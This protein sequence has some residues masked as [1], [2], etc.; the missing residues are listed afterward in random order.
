M[1]KKEDKKKKIIINTKNLNFPS[2]TT[3]RKL[4]NMKLNKIYYIYQISIL[5]TYSA[6]LCYNSNI[7]NGY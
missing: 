7:P 3:K 2:I 6:I 5:I 1:K 4:E